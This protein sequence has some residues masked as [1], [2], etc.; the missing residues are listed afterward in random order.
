MS[1]ATLG[2]VHSRHD[3]YFLDMV[4]HDSQRIRPK[5]EYLLTG[6]RGSN[7]VAREMNRFDSKSTSWVGNFSQ[8]ERLVEPEIV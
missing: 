6:V 7:M 8:A 3:A 5:L 1:L 2:H 4:L